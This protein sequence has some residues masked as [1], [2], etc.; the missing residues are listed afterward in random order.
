MDWSKTPDILAVGSLVW[1]FYSIL[2]KEPR[3]DPVGSGGLFTDSRLWLLGWILIFVHFLGFFVASVPGVVGTLGV[4]VGLIALVAAAIAFI[5]ASVAYRSQRSSYWMTGMLSIAP[6]FYLL[7]LIL[8]SAPG[9]LFL[10]TAGVVALGPLAIG[11][12]ASTKF[13]RQQR[14][15]VIG[16]YLLL[17]AFLMWFGPPR[18]QDGDLAINAIL[19]SVYFCC[20]LNFWSSFRKHSTAGSVISIGGFFAWAM[21]FVI[22]PLIHARFPAAHVEEEVWNLPKYVVAVGMLLLLLEDQIARSQHLALHD[23][24]T[25]LANRRLFQT[26]LT[27]AVGVSRK[28]NVKLGLLQIDLDRFKAVND[29]YGHHVGDLLLKQVA[30]RMQSRI[31]RGDTLARTGGDEF[32]VIL[33]DTTSSE[34]VQSVAVSLG[35]L[36]RAPFHLGDVELSIGASIG[37]AV[38]PTDAH[39]ASSLYIAADLRMYQEKEFNRAMAADGSVESLFRD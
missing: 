17:G 32:S 19:F 1:A 7:L 30:E 10:A 22:A 16:V 38:F 21:V 8:P 18:V 23:E 27:E 13:R 9:W 39:D 33:T 29:T 31:R 20:C 34:D 36:L 3:T 5:R 12:A 26:H 4:A 37:A 14:S 6:S 2:R 35:E 24:L 25:S 28:S 15:M 11:L